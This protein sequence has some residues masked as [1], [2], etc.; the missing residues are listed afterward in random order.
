M[1]SR[2]LVV[3][4]HGQYH[5]TGIAVCRSTGNT[6]ITARSI[7]TKIKYN[8]HFEIRTISPG[9]TTTQDMYSPKKSMQY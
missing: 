3:S 8:A 7:C 1:A 6:N 4:A 5:K 2:Y 9:D